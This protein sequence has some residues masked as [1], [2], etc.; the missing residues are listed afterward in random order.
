M[1]IQIKARCNCGVNT[2]V[3]IGGG[4]MDFTT[5]CHFPCL[6]NTCHTIVQA[7]LLAKNL[8]CAK[9]Q[10]YDLLPYD[11]PQLIGTLG[12]R[13][14]AEWNMQDS[15]GRELVLTD[16]TY[17]CPKCGKMSLIFNDDSAVLWD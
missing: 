14:L 2:D 13:N 4:M 9:C 6:C 5:T 8:Q 7:N 12:N 16:G 10:S 17:K 3:R 1:G 15:L 11:D